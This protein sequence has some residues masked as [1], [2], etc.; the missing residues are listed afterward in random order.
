M[1]LTREQRR[2]WFLTQV[3]DNPAAYQHLRGFRLSG[4]LDIEALR[5]ALA[6]VVT[7][8]PILR[9]RLWIE[10]GELTHEVVAGVEAAVPLVDLADL[11]EVQR[12]RALREIGD[13]LAL[14]PWDLAG[15]T[16]FSAHLVRLAGQ[17]HVLYLGV[18]RIACDDTGLRI[19]LDELGL[20]YATP[21]AGSSSSPTIEER[22]AATDDDHSGLWVAAARLELP[23]DRPRPAQ[24]TGSGGRICRVWEADVLRA[25][26]ALGEPFAWL[27]AGVGALLHRYTGQPR[28]VLGTDL[29]PRDTRTSRVVGPLAV[30]G[31]VSLDLSGGPGLGELTRRAGEALREASVGDR[32]GGAEAPRVV[33]SAVSQPLALHLIGLDVANVAVDRV[34][35]AVDLAVTA[36]PDGAGG[37]VVEVVYATD[38]YDADRVVALLDHLDILLRAGTQEPAR[39]VRRLALLT[40]EERD[41]VLVAWQGP[42]AAYSRAPVHRQ[43]SARAEMS[44]Q[45][46]AVRFEGE[47]V[48]YGE[49]DRRADRLA[50]DLRERGLRPEEIVG[51]ALEP[52][53]DVIV[54]M[55]AIL[56]A[57]G[58][59][60][61]LD[62]THPPQRLQYILAD[63][64]ARIV[65][66]RTEHL[67]AL[68]VPQGWAPILLDRYW[69]GPAPAD[70][71]PDLPEWASELTLAYVLYTSG[72]TGQ[73]KGVLID[74]GSLSNFALWSVWLFDLG[75]HDRMLQ[76]M[77]LIFDFSEGEIFT[78]LCCGA[79]LSVLPSRLRTS[80]AALGEFIESE[81]LT[82]VFGPPA[83]L[84]RVQP[85]A[86]P[87]LKYV[88]VGGEACPG[89]VV[90]AWNTEG[91]RFINGYG[92]TETTVGCIAYETEH[93]P[94][95]SQPPIGRGMPN[96]LAYV[97]DEDLSPLPPGIAG[98]L[99]VGGAGVG[100]GY[101]NRWGLTAERFLPDPFQAGQRMYRT[102]DLAVWNRAGQIQFLGRIDTQV[103]L[104]GLRIELEEIEGALAALPIVSRSAVIVG[105][106]AH[107]VKRLVAYVVSP[108]SP[109]PSDELRTTLRASL[110]PYMVPARFIPV[111]DLPLTSSGKIDRAAM[112]TATWLDQRGAAFRVPRTPVELVLVEIFQ[113]VLGHPQ[114]SMDDNLF[115]LG[116][117]TSDLVRVVSRTTARWGVELSLREANADA[118]PAALSA[119]VTRE[120]ALAADRA[121]AELLAQVEAM[122]LDEVRRSLAGP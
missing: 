68:P 83:V 57:G 15:G 87:D 35:T 93:R 78:A 70:P 12:D 37:L 97:L 85:R 42:V 53:I 30:A 116:G 73:P 54:S 19:L 32:P 33:V 34:P 17:E 29:D 114:V 84:N 113:E 106:D 72:S 120:T 60:A 47:E 121:A 117:S 66:T 91:R 65:L 64:G 50:R 43:I 44:P 9:T 24:P 1:T 11:T 115:A 88:V 90:T 62:T 59:F 111:D 3:A 31:V 61:V 8:H 107:G 77:S 122:S 96:R 118:T 74:H 2:L 95:T 48:S 10:D 98:E 102:G 18:H 67:A 119:V 99:F 69:D 51:L 75:P 89:E 49:L 82:C 39:P 104:N 52:G 13:R 58:A 7:R 109:L 14:T 26:E 110:P 41:Q 6:D 79:S 5:R 4:P 25:A 20:A 81:R 28:I 40:A 80:A 100:R 22:P 46:T 101:L 63:T 108:V 38:R 56:K 76:H 55:V 16:L 27:L 36:Y 112:G 21:G 86:W 23:S 71:G 103:K 105:A 45:A 94:W 92:P